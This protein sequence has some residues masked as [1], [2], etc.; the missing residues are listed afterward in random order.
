MASNGSA[1][2]FRGI[3]MIKK[4]RNKSKNPNITIDCL[5]K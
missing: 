4:S 3:S 5:L 1:I 2:K